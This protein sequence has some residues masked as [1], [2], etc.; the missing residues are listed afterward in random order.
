MLSPISTQAGVPYMELVPRPG[1]AADEWLFGSDVLL[2]FETG[3]TTA[4]RIDLLGVGALLY[5]G[6]ACPSAEIEVLFASEETDLAFVEHRQQR[7]FV[8]FAVGDEVADG[9]SPLQSPRDRLRQF[10]V[11]FN[12]VACMYFA[13]EDCMVQYFDIEWEGG[14]LVD[15]RWTDA[16]MTAARTHTP[17]RRSP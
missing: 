14:D 11:Y 6:L 4:V 2:V 5:S 10:S 7:A 9:P 3:P 16:V 13:A 15:G 17:P 8:E 1:R 12:E